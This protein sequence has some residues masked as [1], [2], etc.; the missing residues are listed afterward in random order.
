MKEKLAKSL[1]EIGISFKEEEIILS[2]NFLDAVWEAKHFL[3]LTAV[4]SKE[5]LIKKHFIDSLYLLHFF[6]F[7]SSKETL[8]DLGTGAGF[9]GVPIKIFQKQLSLYLLEAKR[10]KLNFIKY[11]LETVGIKNVYYL[12]DRA[13]NIARLE[14]HREKYQYVCSRAMASLPVLLEV[15]MPL[16]KVGGILI[17]Y[18]GPRGKEEIQDEEE[19]ITK[20]GGKIYK[21]CFY[22]LPE[23]EKRYI[24]L[25]DKIKPTAEIY[26]RKKIKGK[27]HS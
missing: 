11:T 17:T 15:G 24:Y 9:P 1:K 5:E 19:T 21:E 7:E 20:F 16:L 3:N 22:K 26:P 4:K 27:K 2:A 14:N 8:V 18:K 10:R 6:S 23:G 13:E 25:I 12:H